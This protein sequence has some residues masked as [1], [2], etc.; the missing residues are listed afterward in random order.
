MWNMVWLRREIFE[1]ANL[2]TTEVNTI[3]K[4]GISDFDVEQGYLGVSNVT[5]KYSH[6]QKRLA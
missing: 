2:K 3:C 5:T 4:S 1:I 6:K